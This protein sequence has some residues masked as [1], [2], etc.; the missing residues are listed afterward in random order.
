YPA[1]RSIGGIASTALETC[2]EIGSAHC[3]GGDEAGDDTCT[4]RK[5]EHR[6]EHGDIEAEVD[7]E[8]DNGGGVR[9]EPA[10]CGRGEHH[11][12]NRHEGPEERQRRALGEKLSGEAP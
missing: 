4:N 5:H 8:G 7:I 9:H 11:Y 3:E 10:Q 2:S 1:A 12:R 6:G